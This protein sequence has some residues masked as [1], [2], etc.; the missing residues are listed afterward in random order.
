MLNTV[1]ED[2]YYNLLCNKD[3]ILCLSVHEIYEFIYPGNRP[4]VASAL[5]SNN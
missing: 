4:A 1:G 2:S 5:C 3:L